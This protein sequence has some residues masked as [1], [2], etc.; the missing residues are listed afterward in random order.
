[1]KMNKNKIVAGIMGALT[2]FWVLVGIA[3]CIG[4]VTYNEP[5]GEPISVFMGRGIYKVFLVFSVLGIV[6]SCL[7]WVY[8]AITNG[9][10]QLSGKLIRQATM[11]ACITENIVFYMFATVCLLGAKD[12]LCLL[13]MCIMLMTLLISGI[14]LVI[15]GTQA[16]TPTP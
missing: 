7:L 4:T 6:S 8:Y 13:F 9:K 5:G 15:L 3:S 14:M 10:K 2:A 16:K 12:T 1:M 11:I